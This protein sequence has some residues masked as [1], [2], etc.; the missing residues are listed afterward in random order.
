MRATIRTLLLVA[1][2]M[3]AA[4]LAA[5]TT[6]GLKAGVSFATLSNKEPDWDSRTGFAGG[7][8]FEMRAGAIGLQPEILYVQKGVK[9]NGAPSTTARKLD[10]LEVPLLLKLTVP[11]PALQPFVV[12]GPSVGFRMTC[13]VGEID[14]DDDAVKSTDW[15]AVL[16]AGLRLGGDKGI[17]VEG[18]YTWGLKDIDNIGAGVNSKTRTFLL[19][20]G[21]S[22]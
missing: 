9:N 12:A 15:G 8:S 13:K 4:S 3:P 19:L 17:I 1:L 7:I 11:V 21:V 16:G 20:A 10:Y 14:C 6:V 18:R 5:Q 2:T 22:F